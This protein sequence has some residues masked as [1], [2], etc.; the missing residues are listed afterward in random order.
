MFENYSTDLL[1]SNASTPSSDSIEHPN[2][3]Q[4]Y[5]TPDAAAVM[6][7]EEPDA[8]DPQLVA[9]D[10]WD[11]GGVTEYSRLRAQHYA[12]AGV[13]LLCFSLGVASSL[14]SLVLRVRVFLSRYARQCL[15]VSHSHYD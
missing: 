3:I 14:D 7:L 11:T 15:P 4:K 8:H 9:L 2:S 5:D 1:I 12:D 6:K 13:L 10:I